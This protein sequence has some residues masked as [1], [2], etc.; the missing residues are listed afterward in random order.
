M[1][2][3]IFQDIFLVFYT[4]LTFNFIQIKFENNNM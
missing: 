2:I 4:D 3:I 1:N